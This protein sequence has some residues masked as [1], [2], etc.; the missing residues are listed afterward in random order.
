MYRRNGT[1]KP[2]LF[3]ANEYEQAFLAIPL[4]NWHNGDLVIFPSS[5]AVSGTTGK[6]R[7]H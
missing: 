7:L 6:S 3:D 5:K 1:V 4:F 2:Q